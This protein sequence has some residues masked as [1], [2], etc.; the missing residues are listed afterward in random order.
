MEKEKVRKCKYCGSEIKIKTG[1]HNWKNLL[2]K[3][4][5]EEWI[6]L[7]IILMMVI[8][9]YVYKQDIER[10][11]DYYEGGDYCSQELKQQGI[12]GDEPQQGEFFNLTNFN[13]NDG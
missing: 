2:R 13:L 1:L 10:I 9:T 5:L 6:T 4:T 8:S 7:F 12:T 11:V 3:P